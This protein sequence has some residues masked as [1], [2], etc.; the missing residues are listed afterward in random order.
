V[1]HP[2]PLG[3]PR[4]TLPPGIG[5]FYAQYIPNAKLDILENCGHMLPFEKPQDFATR[6]IDFLSK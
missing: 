4:Q 2:P 1:L 6:T 3:P 5:E